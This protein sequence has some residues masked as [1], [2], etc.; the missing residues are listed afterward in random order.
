M[1]ILK[2]RNRIVVFRLTEEE[3]DNLRNACVTRGARNVSDYA[4]SQLL[5]AME[6][7]RS[8]VLERLSELQ[9]WMRRL[10]KFLGNKK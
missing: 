9:T 3:Y 4:R 2:R 10:E 5:L 6:R 7:D 8:E 1:S